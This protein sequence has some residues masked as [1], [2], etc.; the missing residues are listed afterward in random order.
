MKEGICRL[1]MQWC[2]YFGNFRNEELEAEVLNFLRPHPKLEN[3]TISYYGGLEFPSWL[4]ILSYVN[5]VHLR[6][7]A[8]CRAKALASLGQLSSLKEFYI[9]SL[10]TIRIVGS[11]F[12]G[13]KSPFPSL[14]TLEFKNMP[15]WEDWSHC[16]NNE[17][18]RV[19]FT[20]LK[21]MVIRDCPML[22]GRLPS[23]LSS[24][25]KL[26]INSCPQLNFRGCNEGVLK[27]LVNLTS[28]IALVIQDV[29]ELTYLNYGFISSL[30]K[31]ENLEMK[32]CK[33]LMYL[34]QERD[35]IRNLA[36]LKSLDVK[37]EIASISTERG[38][39]RL[40]RRGVFKTR[41]ASQNGYVGVIDIIKYP[42]LG[43][44]SLAEIPVDR[45]QSLKEIE[46][47]DCENLRSLPQGLHTLSHLT[48]LCL[49]G[50]SVLELECFPPLPPSIKTF[51]LEDCPKIKSLPNQ[52]HR[53]MSLED[54]Q[55]RDCESITRFPDGGLP[56]QLQRLRV[57]RCK[58][59]KQ[60]VREWLTPLTSLC[61]D[62]SAGGVGEEED[63]LLPLPPSLLQF[64]WI[65]GC[66]ILEERCR[67]GTGCYWPLIREIPQVA[68]GDDPIKSIT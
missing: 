8:C 4:G 21:H 33:N 18:V 49:R 63:L 13:T 53:L 19:L 28:L 40:D 50:C 20:C 31:L 12:Y 10:Y 42:R 1:T 41:V 32:S 26:E 6:L 2:K 67:K 66:G 55:I 27:S 60:L 54:L 29:V 9:E 3:L 36:C 35:V 14:M 37:S 25:K 45:L 22:I 61:I 43:V 15:S 7:H 5:M 65:K 59:M 64:L 58:N 46:I 34:W 30:V 51:W 38:V 48:S 17:E 24:L 52:L 68:L 47:T 23:Q 62:G 39:N 11:E 44:E 56:P 57:I 16:F